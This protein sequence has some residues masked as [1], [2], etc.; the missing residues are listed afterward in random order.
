MDVSLTR[1]GGTYPASEKSGRPWARHEP[2][3]T[4]RGSMDNR[5]V[6]LVAGNVV[7]GAVCGLEARRSYHHRG[8]DQGRSAQSEPRKGV[9]NRVRVNLQHRRER[10][11]SLVSKWFAAPTILI[12]K[13][14]A[15]VTPALDDADTPLAARCL[16]TGIPSVTRSWFTFT[17][18]SSFVERARSS[19]QG[20]QIIVI[21][22]ILPPSILRA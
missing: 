18:A 14:A 6:E 10:R 16:D 21:S 15:G 19:R 1:F 7:E 13:A 3:R 9:H 11:M 5:S 22:V 17:F 2:Q 12:F 8:R 20:R 4:W